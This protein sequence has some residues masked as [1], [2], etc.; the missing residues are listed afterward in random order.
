MKL[1]LLEKLSSSKK[2]VAGCIDKN[3]YKYIVIV[4][5]KFFL[6]IMLIMKICCIEILI[7]ENFPIYLSYLIKNDFHMLVLGNR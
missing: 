5:K 1:V 3:L 6:L 2:F 7:N 4:K